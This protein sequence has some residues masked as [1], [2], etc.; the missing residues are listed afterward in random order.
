M[1]LIQLYVWWGDWN[2]LHFSIPQTSYN[3]GKC[4]MITI[5]MWIINE[6]KNSPSVALNGDW[7]SAIKQNV[8]VLAW[9]RLREMLRARCCG[10]GN[11][12]PRWS[13]Q[14]LGISPNK[15]RLV[16]CFNRSI[17]KKKKLDGFKATL[18]IQNSLLK[19]PEGA[20]KGRCWFSRA[21]KSG[22]CMLLS[23]GDKQGLP[24]SL[25][26]EPQVSGQAPACRSWCSCVARFQGER[27][28]AFTYILCPAG[29]WI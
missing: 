27:W 22:A 24:T 3:V 8:D 16:F 19:T 29:L 12:F 20:G 21:G 11:H 23:G 9:V 13:S 15:M 7:D 14:H 2:W 25:S 4:S 17:R 28:Q 26:A 5:A 1:R 10:G 18:S 6:T